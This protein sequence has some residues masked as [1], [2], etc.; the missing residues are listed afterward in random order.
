MDREFWLERWREGRTAFHEGK[1]NT[2][3]A[4][5]F[6]RLSLKPGDRVFVPLCGK[7]EDLDWIV[8]QGCRVVGAELSQTAV[9]AAFERMGFAPDIE[10]LGEM[11]RYRAGAVEIFVGDIFRLTAEALGAVDAVYDRAALVALPEAMRRDYARHLIA[12]TAAAR[13]LLIAF[14]YDQTRMDGPPFSVSETEIRALYTETYAR[15]RA[16]DVDIGGPLAERAG[17]VRETAWLLT[18]H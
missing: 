7:T 11:T 17:S 9:E 15:E 12:T 10:P 1:T 5:L 8:A 14:E 2:F 3:L 4:N 13:Q 18:P 16:I 6:P